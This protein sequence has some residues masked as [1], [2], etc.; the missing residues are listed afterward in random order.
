MLYC[1]NLSFILYSIL[2]LLTY[3]TSFY[4]Y[5]LLSY[6]RSNGSGFFWPTLYVR[7]M[8]SPSVTWCEALLINDFCYEL[9]FYDCTW[10]VYAISQ[11]GLK[12]MFCGYNVLLENILSS[13]ENSSVHDRRKLFL[14]RAESLA[15]FLERDRFA[16]SAAIHKRGE[17]R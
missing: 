12:N 17:G 11:V 3:N 10:V 14:A 16:W 7:T 1:A 8:K 4:H 13:S 9:C 15:M 6:Q 5:P 2:K